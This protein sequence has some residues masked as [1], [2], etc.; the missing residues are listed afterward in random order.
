MSFRV[1]L[2]KGEKFATG[3]ILEFMATQ[4]TK[5]LGEATTLLEGDGQ[6]TRSGDEKGDLCATDSWQCL[7][8]FKTLQLDYSK[9]PGYQ[10]GTWTPSLE[11]AQPFLVDLIAMVSSAFEI[12][13]HSLR[14]SGVCAV[15]RTAVDGCTRYVDLKK[16]LEPLINVNKM[17]TIEAFETHCVK[18]IE[19]IA[20]SSKGADLQL[21]QE[22]YKKYSTMQRGGSTAPLASEADAATLQIQCI[23]GHPP[24]IIDFCVKLIQFR[25]LEQEWKF[26]KQDVPASLLGEASLILYTVH[27]IYIY[28][29]IYIYI[30][31]EIGS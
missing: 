20:E 29:Y 13:I 22:M 12:K 2:E 17:R 19:T 25:K 7:E 9:S 4:I 24:S 31:R 28:I 1:I 30:E 14:G 5:G 16:W 21:L 8:A 27:N 18:R 10:S 3:A 26:M 23:T 15:P 6:V 11:A